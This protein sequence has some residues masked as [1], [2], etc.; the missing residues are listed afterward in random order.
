MFRIL[1]C[2][3]RFYVKFQHSF[4]CSNWTHVCCISL[5]YTLISNYSLVK[6]SN[7]LTSFIQIIPCP[8]WS[9]GNWSYKIVFQ[10]FVWGNQII[11]CWKDKIS[12]SFKYFPVRGP[13]IIKNYSPGIYSRKYGIGV[14]MLWPWDVSSCASFCKFW[15]YFFIAA[16]VARVARCLTGKAI[17]AP[18]KEI[19]PIWTML[20]GTCL[21]VCD[22]LGYKFLFLS[23]YV[24]ASRFVNFLEKIKTFFEFLYELC[25]EF[26]QGCVLCISSSKF[27]VIAFLQH[28]EHCEMKNNT[29]KTI[30]TNERHEE[31]FASCCGL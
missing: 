15:W 9:M 27:T 21:A 2:L 25:P 20:S 8:V 18:N 16:H 24:S 7:T 6:W 11:P 23:T 1:Y 26:C 31:Q 30:N 13:L 3:K 28:Y 10:A 14:F 17:K 5:N 29:H 4:N 22:K 12:H 19:E